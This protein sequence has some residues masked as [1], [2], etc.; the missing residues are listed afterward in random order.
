MVNDEV[1]IGAGHLDGGERTRVEEG[2]D[3]IKHMV[4][5]AQDQAVLAA[6]IS[7]A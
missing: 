1:E 7:K 5:H 2:E 3:I 4:R 6:N